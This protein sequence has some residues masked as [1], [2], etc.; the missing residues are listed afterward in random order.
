[1]AAEPDPAAGAAATASDELAGTAAGPAQ[2]ADDPDYFFQSD[3][4]LEARKKRAV[5]RE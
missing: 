5:V 3:R 1:M 4:E 2:V